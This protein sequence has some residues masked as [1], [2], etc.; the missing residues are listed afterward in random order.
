VEKNIKKS[1]DY[2]KFLFINGNRNIIKEHLNSLK[3]SIKEKNL[4][5]LRPI[6]IDENNYILDGQHRFV[7][8]QELEVPFYYIKCTSENFKELIILNRNQKNW[9][10]IDFANFYSK[11][12]SNKNYTKLLE[13]SKEYKISILILFI[14]LNYNIK[15]KVLRKEFEEG[16]FL[17]NFNE[18]KLKTDLSDWQFC[19]DFLKEKGFDILDMLNTIYFKK[20]LFMF[21]NSRRINKET[22][23]ERLKTN[24]VMLHQCFNFD[25]AINM[26]LKIYNKNSQINIE[27]GHLFI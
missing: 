25:Q 21:L 24:F 8:A 16:N 5:S 11:H 27:K 20:A 26:F 12:F 9:K 14:Y 17:F 4:L 23:W 19:Y 22:F 1:K 3:E 15:K 18:E 7:A 13:I 6:I 10:L 2:E